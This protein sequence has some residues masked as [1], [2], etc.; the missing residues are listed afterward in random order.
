MSVLNKK[1]FIQTLL[2]TLSSEE[3][4]ALLNCINGATSVRKYS[5]V[6]R[7][8]SVSTPIESIQLETKTKIY[9]GYKIYKS[10]KITFL[11]YNIGQEI[12]MYQVDYP[13]Y[14][15]ELKG[16]VRESLSIDELRR[17]LES[18]SGG[19]GETV[20][21]GEIDSEEAEAGKVIV[22][23][24][25]GGATWGELGGLPEAEAEGRVLVGKA[26][27][28][29][30]QKKA[31][32]LADNL[33]A[34]PENNDSP[35][36]YGPTGGSLDIATGEEAYLQ[37]IKGMSIVWNQ[38]INDSAVPSIVGHKYIHFRG[39]GYSPMFTL[40]DG[41]NGY[42]GT[43]ASK[44]FDLTLM[45]G[46]NDKIPFSLVEE[47]EYA[48][49]GS[50]PAQ[51]VTAIQR[52]QRLFA[53][54]DLY[55]A[56]YD[57]GTIKNVKVT[58]LVE[59]GRNLWDASTMSDSGIKLLA[60]YKY[61]IYL[62]NDG[63]N[64]KVLKSIDGTTWN[65]S[66]A[67]YISSQKNASN[68]RICYYTPTDTI[69]V[70]GEEH[71]P[72]LYVGFVHSGNYCLTTGTNDSGGRTSTTLPIPAYHKYEFE[73]SGLSE[74]GLNGIGE[75]CDTKDTT[76]IGSVDL[77]TLTWTQETFYIYSASITGIKPS[78]TNLL[79]TKYI[80][81]EMSVDSEGKITITTSDGVSPTGTLLYELNEPV[82]TGESAFEPIA[83]KSG[84]TWVVDDMG[85]EYF[86]QPA[87]TNCPVNQVAYYY[88]NLKDKL[89]NLQVPEIKS[90]QWDGN[91]EN[92][93]ALKINDT[94]YNLIIQGICRK[95]SSVCIG[96]SSSTLNNNFSVAI[97]SYA[98]G[99]N[100]GTAIGGSAYTSA[101]AIAIGYGS[102]NQ[103]ENTATFDG[104]TSQRQV[105]W[106]TKSPEFIFFRN[107][108]S[109]TNTSLSQYKLGHYLDEFITNK[110]L[111]EN[112]G[113]YYIAYTDQ[114]DYKT[115]TLLVNSSG[116]TDISAGF[117]GAH[118]IV[119][120]SN[121]VVASLDL[122]PYDS[123]NSQAFTA[124][125]IASDTPTFISGYLD[126]YGIVHL[127]A[128]SGITISEV[129]YNLR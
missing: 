95:S 46:G 49:N 52:F 5:L 85:S 51:T 8:L 36:S 70:K 87:N 10:D 1:P 28:D 114:T 38:L 31:A 3:K 4:S 119:K 79:A 83:L 96:Y 115:F 112:S 21:V 86:I 111:V 126:A 13:Y 12:N 125:G 48:A 100:Y 93:I 67:V 58:K 9:N 19:V 53:N 82:A 106:H 71:Y 54:V 42:I 24:G 55:N 57:A 25:E 68:E 43:S 116:Q 102:R 88:P 128:P 44:V 47:T 64:T 73:I 101:Y 94:T 20:T 120:L 45:F 35:Y 103:I 74:N 66:S 62:A 27:G 33:L 104:E 22:S 105:V 15:K 117:T 80:G 127:T 14:E 108:Y 109:G 124:Y 30:E 37:E 77:S 17:Y 39:E 92:L 123:D 65:D 69:F 76:R 72:I 89:V 99:G 16:R 107:A 113:N 110:T 90:G 129:K 50:I 41:N 29:W 61:E 32:P 56:P 60:G 84:D 75:V 98:T 81:S 18:G 2:D 34:D 122:L 78:T 91:N 23:N 6:Q 40:V 59:T 11:M 118:L 121:N 63:L 7:D 26:D 97:G